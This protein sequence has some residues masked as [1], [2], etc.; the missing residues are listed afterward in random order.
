M[1]I[2]HIA[3]IHWGLGYPGPTPT[4]RFDDIC[5]VMDWVADRIIAER[6][7]MVIVAGDMF[8]KADIALDKAS[9]E[10]R[11]CTAWLRKITG[12]GI[13]VV[14]ISGTPSH[15]PISAYELL[16]DYQ[17]PLVSI[18]TERT[19]TELAGNIG[20]V[21]LPGMDRSSFAAKEEYRGLPAHVMHQMMTDDITEFCQ[22]ERDGFGDWPKILVSHLTYDLADTGFEDVLMQ[23]EAILT[24]EAV[25]GYDLVCLGHIHRPQ[26]NGNVFY[27]GSPERLSFNDEKVNAGFWIHDWDGQKFTSHFIDTP[28]RKYES[29]QLFDNAIADFVNGN[30]NLE[31]VFGKIENA[32]VRI[33]YTC[34]EDLNKALNRKTLEKALYDA[35]AFFVTEIKGDIARNDRARDE[36]VTEALGPVEAVR[37]WAA[38]QEF[39]PAEINE[40]AA[41]TAQLMEVA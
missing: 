40:L 41:M 6:C 23:Q 21:L 13:E 32:I 11:A 31:D 17:L 5:R 9:K 14:I 1:K 33:R 38:N 39:D 16:K 12:A 15:D 10:I 7:H 18:D 4:A 20:L 25:Q 22:R 35:G 3:D 36:E 8:R 28:A 27:S 30:T 29:I 2:A 19:A 24:T 26:Q 37:K 34:S